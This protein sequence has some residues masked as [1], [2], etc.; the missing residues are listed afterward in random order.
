MGRHF[1]HFNRRQLRLRFPSDPANPWFSELQGEADGFDRPRYH[2]TRAN[3]GPAAEISA[4]DTIWLVGQLY[5]PWGERLPA[6]IDARIDVASVKPRDGCHGF[7][8]E[9][10]PSSR[11]F[12]LS[13]STC[14]LSALH[15]RNQ[16][17]VNVLWK[18]TRRPLGQYCRRLRELAN[19]EILQAWEADQAGKPLQ[20]ISYRIRD[21]SRPAFRCAQA[22]LRQGHRVFWDRWCLP[23]RLAER[24]EAVGDAPLHNILEAGIKDADTVWGIESPLYSS[25]GSYAARERRLA[26][27]LNKYRPYPETPCLRNRPRNSRF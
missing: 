16:T 23:R 3:E 1:I 25:P 20:F 22:L 14:Q 15:S 9:A 2:V 8:F 7:R 6:A 17:R 24:R 19:A 26:I 5:A 11:W 21:G 4:G 10:A 18:D 12:A 27:S 13:P